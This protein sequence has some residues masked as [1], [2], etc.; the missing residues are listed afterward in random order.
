M[1]NT[2]IFKSYM[3]PGESMEEELTTI[4]EMDNDDDNDE[5]NTLI[6]QSSINITNIDEFPQEI[7][8]RHEYCIEILK[9]DLVVLLE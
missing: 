4:C 1:D 7:S 6:D 9:N 5:S 2:S 3:L 8:L